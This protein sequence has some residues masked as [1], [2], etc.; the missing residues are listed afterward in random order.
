MDETRGNSRRSILKEKYN[1]RFLLR[2][3][4]SYSFLLVII[5]ILGLIMYYY[6]INNVKKDLLKENQVN[7]EKAVLDVDSSF[8]IMSSINSQISN[9]IEIVKLMQNSVTDHNYYFQAWDAK[10][11][12][13]NL[14]SIQNLTFFEDV[15]LYFYET[16]YVLSANEF[17]KSIL[18]YQY[19]KRYKKEYYQEY[20]AMLTD[21]TSYGRP[22]HLKK[23]T[24]VRDDF[25]LYTYPMSI[26]RNYTKAPVTICYRIN[27]NYFQKL[28]AGVNVYDTGFLSITDNSGREVYRLSTDSSAGMELA[29]TG[30]LLKENK[31]IGYV[32]LNHEKMVITKVSSNNNLWNYYLIQPSTM[33]FHNLAFIQ[34]IYWVAIIMVLAIGLFLLI[35]L[36]WKNL[37][38]IKQLESRLMDSFIGEEGNLK[39]KERD[40]IYSIDHYV[41][42]LIDKKITLQETLEH[43]RP[44]IFSAYL[45]RLMK[46][47]SDTPN[48]VEQIA[49]VL[50][51]NNEN[52]N[53]L[54]LYLSVYLNELEFYIDDFAQNKNSFQEIIKEVLEKNFDDR[55][56]L[57]EADFQ[58]F[59]VLIQMES[60]EEENDVSEDN[61]NSAYYD[62]AKIQ[63]HN[64]YRELKDMFSLVIYGGISESF[65]NLYQTWQA[66]QHAMEALRYA[67]PEHILQLYHEINKDMDQYSYTIEMEG[68]LLQFVTNGKENQMVALLKNIY[69]ENFVERSL[70]ITMSK[71]L[72]SD[73]RNTLLKIRF[74]L[75]INFEIDKIRELD[76]KFNQKKS[77]DLIEDIAKE[78]CGI[79]TLRQRQQGTIEKIQ[80]YIQ[81]NYHDSMLSLSKISQEFNI[82]ESY[83]SLQ[84]KKVTNQNFSDYLEKIRIQQAVYLLQATDLNINDITEKTGYTNCVSF[85]RAFKRVLGT[86]PAAL[87]TKSSDVESTYGFETF[88]QPQS[89]T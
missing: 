73:I 18:Y 35:L 31:N 16:D 40:V 47:L 89:I 44:I 9:N 72:L 67:G 32:T 17:E 43:Q 39:I 61:N 45:A 84:F 85:R 77:F 78:L 48:E 65:T 38:P 88:E 20:L 54:V 34:R 3:V 50:N 51:L 71:W 59:A 6:S 74:M 12:L 25:L 87:R 1:D 46:G 64:S 13:Q 15:F 63:F 11:S 19:N 70:S 81:E 53:Y 10:K 86:N 27:R 7:L 30:K 33:V 66:S 79:F 80:D 36:S 55:I 26:Y 62:R 22:L 24:D 8:K 83:F 58:S 2:L 14:L 37:K 75:P 76:D 28:F 23:Y 52:N 5:L 4:C 57:Y 49:K 41:N 56:L 82:S 42:L 21:T 29:D 69:Q 68:Q 60:L